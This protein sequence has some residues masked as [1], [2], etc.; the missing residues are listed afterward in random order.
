MQ[1]STHVVFRFG[2]PEGSLR[3]KVN[4][5]KGSKIADFNP[6][7]ALGCVAKLILALGTTAI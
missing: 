1:K 3:A 6:N 2:A 4:A 7:R 5:F